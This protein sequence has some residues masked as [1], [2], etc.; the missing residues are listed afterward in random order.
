MLMNET[1]KRRDG[2][3]A[4]KLIRH[5]RDLEGYQNALATGLR[6]YELS[7]KFPPV[8]SDRNLAVSPTHRFAVSLSA[9]VS[10]F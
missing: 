1:A 7:K 8:A 2:E 9:F 3:T 4:R 5:F 10:S 6:A